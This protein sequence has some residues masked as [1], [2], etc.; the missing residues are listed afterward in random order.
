MPA[1]F[2]TSDP[3]SLSLS[4]FLFSLTIFRA[5]DERGDTRHF[6][7]RSLSLSLSPFTRSS[8]SRPLEV[9][10]NSK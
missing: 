6:V 5:G 7:R 10:R 2:S 9:L 4:P 1:P 3:L 8:I